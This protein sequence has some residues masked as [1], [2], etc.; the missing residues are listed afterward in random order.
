M[1]CDT[2][3]CS[4]LCELTVYCDIEHY[5]GNDLIGLHYFRHLSDQLISSLDAVNNILA[6]D[7]VHAAIHDAKDLESTILTKFQTREKD[8]LTTTKDD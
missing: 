5:P 3:R 6:V 1:Y 2:E 4:S 7:F 8:C